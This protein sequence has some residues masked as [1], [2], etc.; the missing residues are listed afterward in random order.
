M[1]EAM[2]DE[3]YLRTMAIGQDSTMQGAILIAQYHA[4][5][6]LYARIH[7][8]Y[9]E[10]IAIEGLAEITCQYVKRTPENTYIVHVAL[11]ASIAEIEKRAA[12]QQ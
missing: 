1:E 9:G 10:G 11:Q 2:D 4:Q 6:A 12:E 8:F 7:G 5:Q 3:Q